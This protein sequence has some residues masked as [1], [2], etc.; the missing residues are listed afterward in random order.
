MRALTTIPGFGRADHCG[1]SASH[2]PQPLRFVW[3]HVQPAECGGKTEAGNLVQTCD[4]CHYTVHRLLW[5]LRLQAGEAINLDELHTLRHPPRRSQ[6]EVALRGF[7]A[8]TAAGTVAQIP[9]E[10]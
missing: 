3:H 2:S 6:L 8:C 5:Y 1:I 7:S 4:S 9:N 10:G